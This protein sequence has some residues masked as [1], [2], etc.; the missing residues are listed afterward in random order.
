MKLTMPTFN[1]YVLLLAFVVEI[2]HVLPK[3]K[4]AV[5]LREPDYTS[6]GGRI[7]H[8]QTCIQSAHDM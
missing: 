3:H 4:A 2:L 1:M 6:T 8:C 7:L 5:G